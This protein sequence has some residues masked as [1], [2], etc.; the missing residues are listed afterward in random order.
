MNNKNS[1]IFNKAAIKDIIVLC[2]SVPLFILSLL[3][4]IMLPS[5]IENTEYIKNLLDI[6]ITFSGTAFLTQIYNII[7]QK[8]NQDDEEP[9]AYRKH[10]ENN[11]IG[12]LKVYPIRQGA[13]TS[14]NVNSYWYDL[15]SDFNKLKGTDAPKKNPIRMMGVALDEF[16]GAKQNKISEKITD[17][18]NESAYFRILLCHID[19]R[20]LKLRSELIKTKHQTSNEFSA[21]PLHNLINQSLD[22]LKTFSKKKLEYYPYKFSP[23]ATII[24]TK[25]IIYY[26]PSMVHD[27]SYLPLS[28][29]GASEQRKSE[30]SFRIRRMSNLGKKLTEVFDI[31][32]L[33]KDKF[34]ENKFDEN[35]A[36]ENKADENKIDGNKGTKSDNKQNIIT[37][38][39]KFIRKKCQP[40]ISLSVP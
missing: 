5:N 35:K 37:R 15:L 33:L 29:S 28:P 22:N 32:W 20:G 21:S 7:L 14:E 30:V 13:E 8:K 38:F 6:I 19:N 4:R 9:C 40:Q 23:F 26:T 11:K 31:F 1:S 36:D 12:I 25:N 2:I 17:L 3:V 16:F 24:I 39:F 34:D 18:Y 10:L 27:D